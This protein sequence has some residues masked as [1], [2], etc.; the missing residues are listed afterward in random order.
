MKG[1]SQGYGELGRVKP[2][3]PQGCVEKRKAVVSRPV[4]KDVHQRSRKR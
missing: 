4:V 2:V 1:K 3:I